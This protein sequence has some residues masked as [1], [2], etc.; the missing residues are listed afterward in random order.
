MRTCPSCGVLESRK[1]DTFG[2]ET[3]NLSPL[4]GECVDTNTGIV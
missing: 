4:T 3:V 1:R 2:R